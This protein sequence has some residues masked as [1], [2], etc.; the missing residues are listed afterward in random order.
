MGN[1][2]YNLTLEIEVVGESPLLAAKE[3]E[4]QLAEGGSKYLFVVQDTETDAIFSVDLNESDKDAVLLDTN[5]EPLIKE[6]NITTFLRRAKVIKRI[7][8]I[9]R[10]RG[11]VTDMELELDSSPCIVSI[12]N[13]MDNVSQLIEV[14][15]PTLVEAVT[16]HGEQ[17]IDESYIAYED[18]SDEILDEI[19]EIMVQYD[20][21][22]EEVKS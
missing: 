21:M 1:K 3:L 16:Y 6:G 20:T 10:K 9:I 8:D 5:H 15:K 14:F 11:E 19:L 4:R 18:L 17:Q 13:N 22:N 2:I 12:G 7:Q